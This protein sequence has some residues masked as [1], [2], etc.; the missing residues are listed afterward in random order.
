MQVKKN[1]IQEECPFQ[2]TLA[3]HVT[4]NAQ[5]R[6]DEKQIKVLSPQS[7][8]E[9]KMVFCAFE[10]KNGRE[11]LNVDCTRE[12]ISYIFCHLPA[13]LRNVRTGPLITH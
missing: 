8:F 4:Q 7:S 9:L 13:Y 1:R 2:S 10:M 3:F 6:K 12:S 5:G 11:A